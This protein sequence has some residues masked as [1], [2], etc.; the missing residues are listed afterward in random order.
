VTSEN[1]IIGNN[2]VVE[3]FV[4]IKKNVIIGDGSIIRTGAVIGGAGYEFKQVG[5][6]V[7]GVSHLG[8]VCIGEGVEI[9]HNACVCAAVFPWD[10]T[11]IGSQTKVDNLAYISHCCKI[12]KRN[13]II[14]GAVLC[15]SVVTE[16]DVYIGPN[17]TLS[18]VKMKNRSKASLGSVVIRNVPEGMTVSG[19]FAIE[20]TKLLRS[21]VSNADE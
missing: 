6:V 13:N 4:S 10:N 8:G 3:E 18:R 5:D 2:V 17:A 20:H 12:G 11:V 1:V 9:L 7:V 16:D 21:M 14:G 19:N 15:G